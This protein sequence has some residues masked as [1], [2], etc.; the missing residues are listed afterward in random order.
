MSFRKAAISLLML[1]AFSIPVL[2]QDADQR[3]ERTVILGGMSSSFIGVE[4]RDVTKE[5]FAQAGLLNPKGVLVDRVFEDSP[6]SRAG[7]SKG[8]VILKF[9]DESVTSGRKLQRLVSEVAPDQ[10]VNLTVFRGGSEVRLAVVVGRREG[11][12]VGEGNFSLENLPGLS[13]PNMP[14]FEL[15]IPR[16]GEGE[17]RIFSTRVGGRQIGVSVSP[18]TKQLSEYF[19]V[20]NG[21][22]LLISDVR[23]GSPASKA[24]L[25]AGDVIVSVDGTELKENMDL[26]RVIN[27]KGEGDV[28]LTI[29]R[30]KKELTRTVTPEKAETGLPTMDRFLPQAPIG[31]L[32]RKPFLKL[33]TPEEP[34]VIKIDHGN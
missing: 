8:D 10:T 14:G 33:R 27:R 16:M 29:V 34:L 5:N 21:R 9:D 30:D 15:Q 32:P 7:I 2:A 22:G 4:T 12:A 18:L 13:L 31:L 6:A 3:V 19:G 11:P 1:S 26:I 25:R 28:V 20:K 23:E 24:D 17:T